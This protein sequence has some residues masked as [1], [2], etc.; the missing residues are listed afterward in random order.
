[1]C[2]LK[3][4]ITGAAGFIGFH[5][6]MKL[7]QEGYDVIGVDCLN[8]YY[9]ISLKKDR[10]LTKGIV[11][12]QKKEEIFFKSEVFDNYYF[13]YLDIQNQF[14]IEQMFARE[15]PD[16]VINLAA[17]AGVRYSITNPRQYL[18]SNIDG[19]LNILEACRSYPVKH[20]LYASSSSV[21]G[22]NIKYPFDTRHGVDHPINIYAATKRS[23]ELMAHAYAHLF[24]IP[25][26][27][28]RF[29]TVYGPWGRPDMAPFLFSSAIMS[30]KPI[31]VFN[32][33]EMYRDFTYIDDIVES[34]SRLLTKPPVPSLDERLLDFPSTSTSAFRILNIGN[35]KPVKLRDFIYALETSFGRKALISNYPIQDGDVL[36]TH[37]DVGDLIKLTGYIP[38]VDIK[39]GVD[40]FAKWYLNYYSKNH[41]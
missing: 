26:T 7:I 31:K 27:G 16:I 22:L 17:Q 10:L 40:R 38:R 39:E 23:N 19:F 21:Y 30:N 8:E 28:L 41:Q 12:E 37:A 15:K 2:N 32:N 29:F 6:A 4:L 35:S 24:S 5:L 20:L 9:D 14:G 25:V 36:A 18:R 33:G 11:I 13:Y 3:V 1:M 34:I